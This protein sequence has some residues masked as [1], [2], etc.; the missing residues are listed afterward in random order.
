MQYSPKDVN[1]TFGGIFKLSGWTSINITRDSD[2]YAIQ[3]GADG[4]NGY[5]ALA[6]KSGM[7]E[8]VVN[9][10]NTEFHLAMAAVQKLIN[11]F[12]R[13]EL[14]VDVVL[15]DPAGGVVCYLQKVRLQKMADQSLA[16]E[17]GDRT[18]SFLVDYID[19]TP[20]PYK[21]TQAVREVAN[22]KS[23]A[24]TI[25]ANAGVQSPFTF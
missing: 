15:S 20:T 22:I 1:L 4:V 7:L 2:N 14:L 25:A 3:K 9:Q 13:T 24:E 16:A 8:V 11:K 5:T 17:A 6:D 18:Y 12:P 21:L 19:D 10:T 23:F